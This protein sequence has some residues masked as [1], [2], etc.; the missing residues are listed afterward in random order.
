MKSSK[1]A[2]PKK[3]DAEPDMPQNEIPPATDAS[4]S[5][6]QTR[7]P[8]ALDANS[9]I[10]QNAIPNMSASQGDAQNRAP[11]ALGANSGASQKAIPNKSDANSDIFQNAIPNAS[12]A[13]FD[14]VIAAGGSSL[15][16]KSDKLSAYIGEMTVIAKTVG[17][18]RKIPNA[19]RIVVATNSGYAS[20]GVITA[21]GGKTRAESV[22]NGLRSTAA[23]YVLVH[24]AA[25][26]F[27]SAELIAR[28]MRDTVEFGSAVPCVP[29]ADSMRRISNGGFDWVDRADYVAVQT[30]QGYVRADL[31][32][33]YAETDAAPATDDSEAYS[34]AI[35]RPHCVPGEQT[36]KKI[37][38]P[39]DLGGYNMRTGCGFDAHARSAEFDADIPLVLGGIRFPGEPR[40]IAH[41][42]GDVVLH[43]LTDAM[44]SAIAAG[45]IG[46]M[47]PDDDPRYLNCD[48]ATFAKS[49]L[50]LL[51]RR[52]LRINNASIVIFAQ[53]PRLRER[54]PAMESRIE[55]LLEAKPG[56]VGIC[57]T[58]T[59]NLGIVGAGAIACL[60]TISAH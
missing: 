58:T 38:Y 53:S 3:T 49:A 39:H 6:A 48:S 59:E 5:G 55:S 2:T 46:A 50:R 11:A 17:L 23:K 21:P 10:S 30:P 29:I 40:L 24:D 32:R 18:F 41:S 31:V 34:R 7:A 1:S 36:N 52:N 33:A 43:A 12:D 47:F 57:A 42:D 22:R 19:E 35:G 37:T 15:R 8:I 54:I 45:D 9:G 56:T 14:I 4:S 28:V 27:A 20:A 26:P 16:A 44:L 60:A 13:K 51:K 25:R